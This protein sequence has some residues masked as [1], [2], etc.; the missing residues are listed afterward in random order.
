VVVVVP[1]AA[2]A[3]P[4]LP[5]KTVVGPSGWWS[6]TAPWIYNPCTSASVTAGTEALEEAAVT[7]RVAVPA[8]A[9][10]P[11]PGKQAR[12][13]QAE[14]VPQAAQAAGAAVV[15]EVVHSPSTC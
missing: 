12:L 3:V 5:D 4:V 2:A 1:A 7:A 11:A 9:E 14:T 13:G 6:S 8:G 10:A 15:L